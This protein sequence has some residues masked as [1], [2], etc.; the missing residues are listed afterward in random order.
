MKDE[1]IQGENSDELF[2]HYRIVVDKGQQPL[3]IDKFLTNRIEKV[4]RNRIQQVADEGFIK[5]NDNAVASSYKIK[6]GD[7][8]SIMLPEP[9]VEHEIQPEHIPL[10]I[11]FEDDDIIIVNKPAGL[12]VHPGVGNYTGTLVNGLV[13]HFKN[14]PSQ[15]ENEFRPG[16][17]HRIDKNTSGLLVVAK[18]DYALSFLARQFADHTT[19]RTYVA[20]IWGDMKEEEGTVTGHIGRSLRD[21]QMMAVFP[22]GE[23]GKEAVTHFKVIERFGYTTLVQCNLETGRTHQIRVH[24]KYI[25][26]PVFNDDTYGGDK[27]VKGTVYTRYKQFVENCFALCPRH[28]LHARSLGFIHPVTKEK[29]CFESPLPDDMSQVIDK[30]R[31]YFKQTQK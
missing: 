30:W 7:S 13:Y 12:V 25:G 6:P 16:L 24:M 22:E 14:L 21:R 27:I 3:R 29:M 26:H 10:N 20:L 17:V 2:E 5:V 8:I 18:N 31:K 28:A 23:H 11:V 15:P 9:K 4:S 1:E 19:E